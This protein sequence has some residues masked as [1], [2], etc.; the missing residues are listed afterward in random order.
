MTYRLDCRETMKHG[1]KSLQEAIAYSSNPNSFIDYC[2]NRRGVSPT[3]GSQKV[4]C[5][6]S[7]RIRQ[8][9]SHHPK[10]QFSVK[11]GTSF[12]D[13]AIGL[14]KWFKAACYELVLNDVR[15]LLL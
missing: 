2:A 7:R 10:R 8:H 6:E 11:V 4:K 12:E 14:D 5:N 3:C 9:G 13:S 15:M 1:P